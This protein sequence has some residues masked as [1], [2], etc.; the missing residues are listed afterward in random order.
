MKILIGIRMK[1]FAG[2]A[3]EKANIFALRYNNLT[4]RAEKING[5]PRGG[6]GKFTA[7]EG[8]GLQALPVAGFTEI[9]L[10]ARSGVRVPRP[11]SCIFP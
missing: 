4:R 5:T 9:G 2:E 1:T 10:G 7:K 11:F 8:R 3:T 6:R